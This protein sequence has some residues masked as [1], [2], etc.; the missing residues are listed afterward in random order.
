MQKQ[1]KAVFIILKFPESTEFNK[2]IPKQK[3]YDN[4]TVSGK[5]KKAFVE[6][7][8]SIC[9]A[10]KI[11]PETMNISEGKT[12]SEIEVFH[13]ALNCGELDGDVLKLI[14][15]NIPYNILFVLEFEDKIRL[16]VFHNKLFQT[17][18]INKDKAYIKINGFDTDEI[19]K[20]FVAEIGG[21]SVDS[22]NTLDE[23]IEI[24]E[25]KEK[26]KK[27]IERLEKKLVAE[28]QFNR[29]VE[30]NAVIKNLKKELEISGL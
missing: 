30:L 6:K 27:E 11:S 17:D 24:D 1:K 26:I 12:V 15:K 5:L 29:Q 21:I 2:K 8:K 16:A 25:K 19:W 20:S 3:Y 7:I 14:S 4:M 13:I 28:K 23:Q 10:N 22:G 9:W 18:W